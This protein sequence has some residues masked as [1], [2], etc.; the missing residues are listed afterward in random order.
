MPASPESVGRALTPCP[1]P[2]ESNSLVTRNQRSLQRAD[3][4]EATASATTSGAA[5]LIILCCGCC[6]LY[7]AAKKLMDTRECSGHRVPGFLR[8]LGSLTSSS[9]KRKPH[10]SFWALLGTVQA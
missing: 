5:S 8:T 3:A 1:N 10:G 7:D 2:E 4:T 9:G 6:S